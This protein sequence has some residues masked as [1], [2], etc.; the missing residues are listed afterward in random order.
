MPARARRRLVPVPLKHVTVD[1]AFWTPRLRTNRET[2]LPLEY[3]QCKRTGR[4]DQMKVRPPARGKFYDSDA[5]KWI[6]AA[7]YALTAAPDQ[8]VERKIDA[9]V[10]WMQAA[11]L[12]DGYLNSYFQIVGIDRRWTNLH[13]DHEL[14]CAGHLMEAAVAYFQA[15]GK[16]AML[17]VMR[18]C[19]DH[20]GRTFGRGKGQKRGYPGHPEIELALVKLYRA[21]GERRHLDLAAYFVNERGRA[22]HYFEQEALARGEAPQPFGRIGGVTAAYDHRQAHA[23]VREQRTAD[24]HSVCALYLYAGMADVA[25]ETGDG[26]LLTACRR[27]WRNVTE[28][29]MYVHGGVGSTRFGERFTFDYDLPEE[30]AYAE[31]CANIALVFFAHRMLQLEPRAEYADVLE[32]ALYNSVL[33]GVSADGTRFFYANW[34]AVK[35]EAHNFRE[36]QKPPTRQDW[37]GCAC[38]PPNLARMLASLGQYV[39]MTTRDAVYVHL[40]TGGTAKCTVKGTPVTVTQKTDYPWKERVRLTVRPEDPVNFTLALR[41]PGWCRSPRITVAGKRVRP[42]DVDKHGYAHI[43]RTWRRGDRVE[44][45]LPMPVERVRAHPAVRQAAGKTALQ[46]GPVVYCL[47][48][49][50]NGPDLAD[51][52]LPRTAAVSARFDRRF[53]G[54]GAVVLSARARRTRAQDKSLYTTGRPRL[55]AVRIRAVPYFLWNNR[56][57]GEMRIW[58]REG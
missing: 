41:L 23:P 42:A 24:G 29:R 57:E 21:T 37:F 33:S 20:I 39:Y 28:K 6:E 14:Y 56:G 12:G 17:D 27:L 26:T 51:V 7:A 38:C 5:A 32:R 2:T 52:A 1:G 35:P 25:M 31:T 55:R 36:R 48:E 45:R 49:K 50:D 11:Q 16:R 15:T 3:D 30:T 13:Q 54:G 19:A 53:P 58:L 9:Y 46:R 22:P 43:R 47:E 8:A 40:Y 44:L 4:L 34:P 10:R 18:R